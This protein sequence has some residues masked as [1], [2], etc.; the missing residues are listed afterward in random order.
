MDDRDKTIDWAVRNHETTFAAVRWAYDAAVAAERERC[1]KLC[2]GAREAASHSSD[3]LKRA[4]AMAMA[5][6]C[7]KL[8]L[9]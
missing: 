1:A 3:G 4:G 5:S 7:A 2:E 6:S 8:I 9:A